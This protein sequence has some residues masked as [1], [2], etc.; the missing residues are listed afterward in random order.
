MDM[1]WK[2]LVYSF[3]VLLKRPSL[4]AVAILAIGLGIGAPTQ[5]SSR[6]STR[7]PCSRFPTNSRNN[8]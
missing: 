4:A 1:L 5:P 3:R 8:S 6:S 7:C 2:N